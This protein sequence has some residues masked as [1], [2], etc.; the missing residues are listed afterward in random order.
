MLGITLG[1]SDIEAAVSSF[2]AIPAAV[3]ILA[4]VIGL[5][6]IPFIAGALRSIVG[7]R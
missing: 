2:F 3:P 4:A 5:A 1:I 7:R 6:L